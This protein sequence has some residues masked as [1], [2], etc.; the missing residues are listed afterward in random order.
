[1]WCLRWAGYGWLTVSLERM[2]MY[3][4]RALKVFNFAGRQWQAGELLQA[5]PRD[6]RLLVALR[7]AA[8]EAQVQAQP[9]PMPDPVEDVLVEE[10]AAETE[11]EPEPQPEPE[12]APEPEP[13]LDSEKPRKKRRYF[14]RDMSAEG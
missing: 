5:N 1:V 3:T 13:E 8:L 10:P 9:E 11:V 12:P 7:R 14:R 2:V 4:L 6:A